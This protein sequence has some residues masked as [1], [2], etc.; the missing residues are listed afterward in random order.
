MKLKNAPGRKNERRIGAWTR[1]CYKYPKVESLR[2]A[3]VQAEVDVLELR[4]RDEGVARAIQTKKRR[5][6]ARKFIA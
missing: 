2:P 3:R 6:A 5:T 4:I 1:L